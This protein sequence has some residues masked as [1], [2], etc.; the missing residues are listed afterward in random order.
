MQKVLSMEVSQNGLIACTFDTSKPVLRIEGVA[1]LT[2]GTNGHHLKSVG[3]KE[4][5][6]FAPVMRE[7]VAQTPPVS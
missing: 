6:V 4:V 5:A 2:S 3:Y 7:G 1:L